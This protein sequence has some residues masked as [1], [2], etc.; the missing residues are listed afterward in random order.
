[1]AVLGGLVYLGLYPEKGEEL[2]ALAEEKLGDRCPISK[3][4]LPWS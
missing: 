1:M 2:R 3:R 4:P